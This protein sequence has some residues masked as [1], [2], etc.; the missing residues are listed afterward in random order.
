MPPT[1]GR[2]PFRTMTTATASTIGSMR[3]F[4]AWLRSGGLM[5]A[6]THN[7]TERQLKF[8]DQYQAQIHPLY[9]GPVHIGVIYLVGLSVIGWCVS[10]LQGAGWEWL[11]VVPVFFSNLFEW[12]IHK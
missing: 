4:S 3:S 7:P 5:F 8:R 11:L 2:V 6:D 1:S 12:W 9:S 10:R